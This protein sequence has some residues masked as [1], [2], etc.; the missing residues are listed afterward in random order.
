MR[1]AIAMLGMLVC[2]HAHAAGSIEKLKAFIAQTQ[3]AR[4]SF[5]QQVRGQGWQDGAVGERQAGLL[6]AR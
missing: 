3:S 5:T 1:K 2:W 6:A 4:A